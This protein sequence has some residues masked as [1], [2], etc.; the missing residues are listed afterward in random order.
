MTAC[1]PSMVMTFACCR[2]S[3]NWVMLLPG[4]DR[5][6]KCPCY[7]IQLLEHKILQIRPEEVLIEF[8]GVIGLGIK[9]HKIY[10][11][12]MLPLPT[13]VVNNCQYRDVETNECLDNNG[14]C[15]IH[16]EGES[17][18]VLWLMVCNSKETIIVTVKLVGLEGVRLTMVVVGMNHET[19]M[20]TLIV[21][22]L[23][24]VNASVLQG[25][26]EMVSKVVKMLTNAKRRKLA[27]ALNVAAKIPGEA[28][29][30]LVVEIFCIS[31]TMILA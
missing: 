2:Q 17:V 14:G 15:W 23:K 24:M 12:V 31:G 8:T 4:C 6:C 9:K 18:N 16:F 11:Q 1:P 28:T 3:N 25:L 5:M 30:A 26:K 20:H 7:S 21:W 22:I 10:G 13:L 19:D 27:S 29:S